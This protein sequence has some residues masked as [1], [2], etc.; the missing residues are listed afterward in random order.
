MIRGCPPR[1]ASGIRYTE[2]A[3][4][5]PEE[6]P[7]I[8]KAIL[9]IFILITLLGF[10][11]HPSADTYDTHTL[12][13][14]TASATQDV[15]LLYDCGIDI[16]GRKGH[17]FRAL[18]TPD[19]LNYLGQTG[20]P[21]VILYEEMERERQEL[22]YPGYCSN[23]PW[24]CYY[25]AASF[26]LVDPPAGSVMGKL[27][28]LH[29]AYPNITRLHDIGDS[30]DGAYDIIAMQVTD[31]PDVVEAEPKI[32]MYGNIHG[33]ETGAMMVTFD[34]LETIL[35]RY[36]VNDPDAVMLVEEAESWFIPNG[37][38]YGLANRTRYNSRG[39][40]LN[41]NFWGPNGNASGGPFSEKETQAIR[42]LTEVIGKRFVVS[43][44]YHGGA[45]V[46]NSVYNYTS[47]ATTDE[48]IFF[49]S[50]TGGPYG[51]ANPA[52]G[53][54]AAAYQAG[55]DTLGFW[56]S[57]GG[58]W[59]VTRG[60]TNDWSYF[61][62]SALDTT[63][64]VTSNKWPDSDLIRNYTAEHREASINYMLK[65]FQGIHGIMSDP[66]TGA[67]LDGTVVVTCTQSDT[68]ST[69]H[70]YK[71][72]YT[73][74]VVGD[75][76]R[77]LQPGTYTVECNSN[78]YDPV[79]ITDVVV[80]ADTPTYVD[81]SM[82]S[83]VCTATVPATGT[84]N[85]PVSFQATADGPGS[86]FA[87][88]WDF[89]DGSTSDQQ[90][91]THVYAAAGGYGWQL[92]VTSDGRTCIQAGTITISDPL[93]PCALTCSASA[94]PLQGIVPHEVGFHASSQPVD[95]TEPVSYAWDFGDGDTA[96]GGDVTHTYTDPGEYSWTLTAEAD[97][98][99]CVQT[100]SVNVLERPP[101]S[102]NCTASASPTSGTAPLQVDFGSSVTAPW[103]E[104]PVEILWT[105]GDG[106]SSTEATP[107]HTYTDAGNFVWRLEA[108]S[109]GA[110]CSRS[111]IITVASPPCA[112]TC[113][114]TADPTQGTAPHTVSFAATADAQSCTGNPAFIWTFGDGSSSAEQSPSHAYPNAGTYTWTLLV[115]IEDQN[116]T[117]SGMI[118]VDEPCT[119]TCS[120][121][122][123]PADGLVPLYVS[124]DS[125][126]F[127]AD[128]PGPPSF[129]WEFGDG[130]TST[131][132]D[133]AHTYD[134]AGVFTWTLTV[135]VDGITCVRTGTVTAVDP[136]CECTC[137]S[138]AGPDTG[139][140]P[141]TVSFASDAE[142]SNCEGA[143][144]YLWTFGDGSTATTKGAAHTYT[145]AGTFNWTYS[146]EIDGVRC[147]GGGSVTVESLMPGDCNGDGVVTI[148]EVQRAIN[149][150]LGSEA[151]GCG[152]DTNGD[153]SV[154]IGEVQV[155]INF[156][157]EL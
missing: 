111:G 71:E 36:A 79:V 2:P 69:P 147:T 118:T 126:A 61:V 148:G 23:T 63:L 94:G 1:R 6:H 100:G 116:C 17:V 102:V 152:V 33:D 56:Y 62:W 8:R 19:E 129:L 51:E 124:F 81:C 43:L 27:L 120:A 30:Q 9:P 32:R 103:C 82:A 49:S 45:I 34:V 119:L 138:S 64:E 132:A 154:T 90:N 139:L 20:L 113:T 74:P 15:Q 109:G 127:P 114:A 65:A 131:D 89:G 60:D 52:P 157:I 93:G 145:G 72:V 117:R 40:D 122:A 146:V 31:N 123:A 25:D 37:N 77:V 87:Y 38:P 10:G 44:S 75:Y 128:C 70:L 96:A 143:P 86:T 150:F 83:F 53:G 101:C 24:P 11:L 48:P 133:P 156:F 98:V 78:G 144:Q 142:F 35:S 7:L 13:E 134:Q 59:Y 99:Y 3:R 55:C 12:V 115:E 125:E 39:I 135:T 155:V 140:S 41:R 76:H 105:F 153:G 97:G 18:I 107:S 5:Q 108:S 73:D 67:P 85:E 42:D 21:V 130:T 84:T 151:I 4:F 66:G 50:R 104:D 80:A 121:S 29:N 14:I 106:S 110:T 136:P 149:M 137:N 22:A 68:I 26:N 95:C 57:N 58:D 46:F 92:T 16:V 28:E 112:L 91:T 54:L 141:L 88:A 47:A